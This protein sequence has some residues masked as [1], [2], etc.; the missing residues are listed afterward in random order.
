LEKIKKLD[1]C[2]DLIAAFHQEDTTE[3]AHCLRC[4]ADAVTK[5]VDRLLIK[6][7]FWTKDC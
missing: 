3:D 7:A 2:D 6:P 4:I 5:K 1:V